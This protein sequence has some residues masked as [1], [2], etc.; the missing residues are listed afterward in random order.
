MEKSL[1]E[2]KSNQ[3][4]TVTQ[5]R[6]GRTFKHRLRS[7]GVRE[8]QRISVVTR[9]PA[10]PLVINAGKT[11]LTIGRGMAKKIIIETEQ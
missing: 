5:L 9:Q 11:Q 10:G 7:R 3:S 6:G 8:D 4:G 2:M 1:N